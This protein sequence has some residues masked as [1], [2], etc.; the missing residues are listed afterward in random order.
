M[1]IT[2]RVVNAHESIVTLELDERY[3]FK[4]DQPAEIKFRAKDCNQELRGLLWVLMKY[5]GQQLGISPR[6]CY[7][8]L[9]YES[10]LVREVELPGGRIVTIPLSMANGAIDN[11]NLGDFLRFAELWAIEQGIDI[12]PYLARHRQIRRE[13]GKE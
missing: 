1:T 4:P 10:G 8:A 7:D 11:K 6:E 2:G 3:E 5:L 9:K 12:E 13:R